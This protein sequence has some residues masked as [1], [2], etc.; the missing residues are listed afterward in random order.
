M[1][2]HASLIELLVQRWN[3]NMYN[4]FI[5]IANYFEYK[6]TKSRHSCI[7]LIVSSEYV[8]QTSTIKHVT[9]MYAYT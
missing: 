5:I 2:T 6:H 7:V 3:E 4:H 9:N 1:F 8:E